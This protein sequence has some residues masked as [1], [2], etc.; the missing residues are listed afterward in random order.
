MGQDRRCD[1]ELAGIRQA[2]GKGSEHPGLFCMD[3]TSFF[4]FHGKKG[5]TKKKKAGIWGKCVMQVP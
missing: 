5:R 2:D 4:F 1:A 3:F